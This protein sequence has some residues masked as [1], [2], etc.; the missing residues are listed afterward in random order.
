M[1]AIS[2]AIQRIRRRV[3]R[4]ARF[5]SVRSYS[6]EFLNLGTSGSYILRS[7]RAAQTPKSTSDRAVQTD[8]SEPVEF[9]A[10]D[11]APV[12]SRCSSRS[13]SPCS[14]IFC[15]LSAPRAPS[16][17]IASIP[18]LISSEGSGRPA[19][20]PRPVQ[21]TRAT[22]IDADKVAR[23]EPRRAETHGIE[24]SS[25]TLS[26]FSE[27]SPNTF[28]DW[29]TNN[30]PPWTWS[31]FDWDG[32]NSEYNDRYYQN[33]L[34]ERTITRFVNFYSHAGEEHPPEEI[35]T[36][37]ADKWFGVSALQT[38]FHFDYSRLLCAF[39]YF[40]GALLFQAYANF[41]E[42]LLTDN[43]LENLPDY[44]LQCLM[45]YYTGYMEHR[46]MF[47]PYLVDDGGYYLWN[48]AKLRNDFSTF[49]DVLSYAEVRFT[50]ED[51]S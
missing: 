6:V 27:L 20:S 16:N 41:N 37:V 30:R 22:P 12:H 36:Y 39:S 5:S 10:D 40:L 42:E 11:S 49:D 3:S 8:V 13:V 15:R 32:R 29:L 26:L 17:S 46:S 1:D 24:D 43:S 35:I 45:D 21:F 7:D 9:R 51:M 47:E 2:L 28:D 48:D 31:N 19:S 18:S 23:V 50:V 25:E 44:P 14:C 38:H 33:E 34:V 4:R